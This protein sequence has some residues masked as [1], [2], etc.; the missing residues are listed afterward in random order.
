MIADAIG[1][2]KAAVYHQFKTKDE[3]VFAVGRG[4]AREAGSGAR[5][6]RSRARAARRARAVLAAGDRPRRRAPPHGEHAARRSRDRPVLRRARAVPAADGSPVPGADRRRHRRRGAGAAAMLTAAIGG[7]VMHP[8]VLDLDDDMLRAQLLRLAAAS[9]NSRTRRETARSRKPLVSR[10][11][12]STLRSR[13]WL[14]ASRS[15]SRGGRRRHRPARRRRAFPPPSGGSSGRRGGPLRLGGQPG[16]RFGRFVRR[17]GV[18][19]GHVRPH[20]LVPVGGE[21]AGDPAGMHGLGDDSVR[22]APG[23]P[24]RG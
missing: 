5:R 2:T 14:A 17:D 11:C 20:G 7:A 22:L 10:L 1:V 8:L 15:R 13:A 4:R 6:G 16:Q 21:V 3:I 9:S 23:G 19:R 18:R 12:E 24:V